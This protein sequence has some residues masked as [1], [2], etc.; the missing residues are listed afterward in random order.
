MAFE[1]DPEVYI[2]K[3]AAELSATAAE[4]IVEMIQEVLQHKDRFTF[5]LSGG[6]TPKELYSLLSGDPYR[7]QIAWDKIH[8]FWGDERHVPPDHPDS[9]YRSAQERMLSKVPLPPENIHR[10]RGETPDAQQAAEDYEQELMGLFNLSAGQVPK[11]DCVLLGM[12]PDGHIA[13]LFPGTRAVWEKKRLVVSNWVEKFMHSRITMTFP[14]LNNA[15]RIIFLVAGG[16]KAEVLREVLEGDETTELLPAQMIRPDH[17][18]VLWLVDR[19]AAN[20][21]SLRE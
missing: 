14:V 7:D 10:V 5:A 17:G 21:L 8:F 11:L 19:A 6:S 3:N 16:N 2:L 12:G 1:T 4:L 20:R 13:S 18:N 15:R 9:N